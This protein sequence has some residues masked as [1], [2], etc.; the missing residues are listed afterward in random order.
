MKVDTRFRIASLVSIAIFAVACTTIGGSL[1]GAGIGAIAGDV[2]FG[3]AVGATA[4]AVVD[5]WGR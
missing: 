3:A 4:G 1:V 2:E 5:I